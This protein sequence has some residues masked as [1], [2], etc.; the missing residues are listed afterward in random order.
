MIKTLTIIDEVFPKVLKTLAFIGGLSVI[1][2][3]VAILREVAGR[4][5]F[6]APSSWSIEITEHLL[7]SFA[8]LGGPYV[9]LMNAH[10]RADVFYR[11]FSGKMKHVIDLLIYLLSLIYLVV[12]TWRCSI[13][14]YE[15]FTIWARSS[16]GA[17]LP[18]FP[19]QITVTIGGA[20]SC[21]ECLRKMAHSILSIAGKEI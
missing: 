13:Y 8:F 9:F 20:L 21:I 5:F 3:M 11:N 10:V 19:A 2:M 15:I 6:N 14:S 18:L 17:M 16:G 7:V 4:Y 12:L 1:V